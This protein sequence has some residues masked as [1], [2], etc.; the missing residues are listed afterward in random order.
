MER[1]SN[2][3]AIVSTRMT[4]HGRAIPR[5]PAVTSRNTSMGRGSGGSSRL[6][7]ASSGAVS[8]RRLRQTQ[9]LQP[10]SQRARMHIEDPGRPPASLDAPTRRLEHPAEV[11]AL[12]LL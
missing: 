12:V 10:G 9:A 6:D 5:V 1:R 2:S 7:D 8:P 3:R 4:A 11:R